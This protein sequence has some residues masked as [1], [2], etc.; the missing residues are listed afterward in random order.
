MQELMSKKSCD[1]CDK[2]FTS[3]QSLLQHYSDKHQGVTPPKNVVKRNAL[4]KQKVNS[5]HKS[6]QN[7]LLIISAIAVIIIVIAAAGLY[8]YYSSTSGTTKYTSDNKVS[9]PV[10][11]INEGN[12]ALN[13]P[14]TLTNGTTTSLSKFSDSTVLLYF[15]ATWCPSCQQAAQLL[16]QQYY[17][18]LHSKG[19]VILTIELYND[20][21]QQGPSIEQ[22]ASQ[23][24]GGTGKPG[25]FFGTSTQ[26]AT[27]TYDPSANLEAYYL[28]N[29]TGAIIMTTSSTGLANNLPSVV[30]AA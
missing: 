20:L 5:S 30:N 24:T 9:S 27:Y 21:N 19:V 11:G 8:Y 28:I 7:R 13:I 6:R 15:V 2:E 16:D 18:Q 17:S 3:K 10:Y 26:N 12:Y 29:D 23:Y 1:L 25:W 22:F 14:I 4:R